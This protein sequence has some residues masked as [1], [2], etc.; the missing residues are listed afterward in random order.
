MTRSRA[1]I[2][3]L[4]A[5]GA[6]VFLLGLSYVVT[7]LVVAPG[8]VLPATGAYL[9]VAAALLGRLLTDKENT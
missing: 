1:D 7:V 5:V 9:L 6:V 2:D 3:R 4:V 8:W